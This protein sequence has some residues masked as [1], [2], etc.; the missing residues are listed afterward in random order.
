[1]R[2]TRENRPLLLP[3]P[4]Q[5]SGSVSTIPEPRA[6][7]AVEARSRVSRAIST[8][9]LLPRTTAW[10]LQEGPTESSSRSRPPPARSCGRRVSAAPDPGARRLATPAV[11]TDG[12]WLFIGSPATGDVY[13]LNA[14]T[15]ALVWTRFVDSCGT[16]AVTVSGSSLLVSGCAVYALSAANGAMLWHSSKVGSSISAP[17]V[18]GGLVFVTA[19]GNY[20]G[21]FAL[22]RYQPARPC[23][24]SPTFSVNSLH[25][26]SPT[27]SC[28]L[29]FQ[30]SAA[31][32][33]TT[34][35]LALRSGAWGP[36]SSVRSQ[37][38]RSSPM[39]ASTSARSTSRPTATITWWRCAPDVSNPCTT[40]LGRAMHSHRSALAD[41]RE[42]AP[43]T[44][45]QVIFLSSARVS[46]AI[47]AGDII[48]A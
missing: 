17:A 45:G 15:G 27:V 31:W 3:S 8:R 12:K 16:S 9:R 29:I 44:V 23:G 22:E 21:T 42:A 33:C 18:A 13:K 26:L 25:R 1:M 20:S 41:R 40:A 37:E 30:R 39:D 38:A 34:A 24:R 32:S 46:A 2:A 48:V 7:Q 28:M 47:R 11:S 5:R 4:R 6:S 36:R 19:V 43:A 35:A 10:S 14:Q